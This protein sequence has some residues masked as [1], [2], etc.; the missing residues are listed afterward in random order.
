MGGKWIKKDNFS[1][2]QLLNHPLYHFWH[3]S[4]GDSGR[5]CNFE[6]EV[7]CSH[8]LIYY[9]ITI[10]RIYIG[11]SFCNFCFV[12]LSLINFLLVISVCTSRFY[13]VFCW[14]I[15]SCCIIGFFTFIFCITISYIVRTKR[16][17]D[18]NV[19]SCYNRFINKVI[20]VISIAIY[21]LICSMLHV[22]FKRDYR[23]LKDRNAI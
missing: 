5:C 19:T 20:N 4:F 12:E 13:I 1:V 8:L 22:T 2:T 23:Q 11:Y 14:I 17:A 18:L 10:S 7:Q 3:F 16:L 6:N 15:C 9:A 21:C